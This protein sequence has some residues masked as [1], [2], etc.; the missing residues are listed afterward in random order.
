MIPNMPTTKEI[1][2]FTRVAKLPLQESVWISFA[3]AMLSN[4]ESKS[5]RFAALTADEMLTE[6]NKRFVS[7]E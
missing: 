6:Y 3:S 2:E 5:G 4:P 1:K 7:D